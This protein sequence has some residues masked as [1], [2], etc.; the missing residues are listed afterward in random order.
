MHKLYRMPVWRMGSHTKNMIH[1]FIRDSVF[2]SIVVLDL[3]VHYF[4]SDYSLSMRSKI[5]FGWVE[6][7]EWVKLVLI[8]S[9][10]WVLVQFMCLHLP[11][12]QQHMGYG[13]VQ[14]CWKILI[15]LKIL[16]LLMIELSEDILGEHQKV[17]NW[18]IYG[19]NLATY[20]IFLYCFVVYVLLFVVQLCM[21]GRTGMQLCVPDL[22]FLNT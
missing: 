16:I 9:H 14:Q 18:K 7:R 20:C 11:I 13:V 15:N 6:W 5:M 22:C 10:Y 19:S 1:G 12:L 4:V 17:V 21:F 2:H 8:V 3:V